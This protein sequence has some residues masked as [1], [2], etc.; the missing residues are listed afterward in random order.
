MV[1]KKEQKQF[2]DEIYNDKKEELYYKTNVVEISK[3]Q[4]REEELF[5][6]NEYLPNLLRGFL[7]L[8]YYSKMEE[9]GVLDSVMQEMA[10]TRKQGREKDV[11]EYI[12]WIDS[13]KD[14][15]DLLNEEKVKEL[16]D[17]LEQLEKDYKEML[18]IIK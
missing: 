9:A 3:A 1:S 10:K 17:S 15:Q 18:K 16:G 6:L 11:I 8:D 14:F 13:H 5:S 2:L 7:S 12:N 4:S